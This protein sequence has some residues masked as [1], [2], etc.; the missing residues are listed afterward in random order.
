[1][2]FK[3][4]KSAFSFSGFMIAVLVVTAI[5]AAIASAYIDEKKVTKIIESNVR[6]SL[7]N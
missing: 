1:M 2:S 3:T 5:I 6:S 4:P 7:Q